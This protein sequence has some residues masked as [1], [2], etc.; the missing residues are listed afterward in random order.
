MHRSD[1]H[2]EIELNYLTSGSLRY[3][4]GGRKVE[5][6][7]NQLT[8]F[9]AC[10]PHQVLS[11]S[12][13]TEYFVMTIPL[14]WLLQWRLPESVSQSLLHGRVILEEDE[15][16]SRDDQARFELWTGDLAGASD[17]RIRAC[18]LEVEARLRRLS[19]S[20]KTAPLRVDRR[21]GAVVP[22]QDLGCAEEMASYIALHFSEPLSA[23]KIA[24]HVGLHPNYAMTLFR[25][26]FGT[27]LISW[28]TQYRLSHAQRLLLISDAPVAEVAASS[29]FGSLSRF[30]QSFK[31]G[32][33][34]TPREFRANLRI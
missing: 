22:V 29:G 18:A 19:V 1:R 33:G 6:R 3:L 27:T 26:T 4:L 16:V 5:V 25:E 11:F 17:E 13:L 24:R 10:V 15:G 12:G 9:W 8:A 7:A 34:C 20:S 31:E 2:N 14:A 28:I 21:A 32:V 23:S 30:H